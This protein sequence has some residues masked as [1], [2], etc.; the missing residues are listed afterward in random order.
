MAA[1]RKR[2]AVAVV[3]LGKAQLPEMVD[4]LEG[5]EPTVALSLPYQVLSRQ[6]DGGVIEGVVCSS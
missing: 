5:L 6:T 1:V 2:R 3:R 4:D